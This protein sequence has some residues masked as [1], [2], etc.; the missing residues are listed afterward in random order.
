MKPIVR[1]S[2]LLLLAAGVG[3]PARGSAQTAPSV[4]DA[5]RA[6]VQRLAQTWNAGDGNGW[7]A[8]FWS[9]GTLINILGVTFPN[10]KA[11]ADVTNQ[12][13]A[14]PF[15]GSTFQGDVRRVRTA[16]DSAAIADVDI[17]VTNFRGLPP[18]AVET[19][20]GLLMTKFTYVFTKRNGAWKIEAA[21]NT[22]VLPSALTPPRS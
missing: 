21:Q 17:R 22:A 12:I 3:L 14:G 4:D 9:D 1:A 10:A 13:L 20:P 15:K 6:A 11:V 5:V 2:A 7:A 16:G 18:G 8:E 19:A